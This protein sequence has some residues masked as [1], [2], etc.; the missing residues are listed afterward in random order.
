[1]VDWNS[2]YDGNW[3]FVTDIETVTF[4]PRNADGTGGTAVTTAKGKRTEFT[5]AQVTGGEFGAEP[6]DI[7]W[8]LWDSTLGGNT[9][10]NGDWITDSNGDTFIIKSMSQ[11]VFRTEWFC[12]CRQKV[13]E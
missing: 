12:V 1:M 9:P 8:T 5:E 3:A 13:S 6:N 2:L 7:G 10:K 11:Q 4:T